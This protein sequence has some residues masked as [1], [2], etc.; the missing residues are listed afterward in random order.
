MRVRAVGAARIRHELAACRPDLRLDAEGPGLVL[1]HL[2]EEA[3]PA[4]RRAEIGRTASLRGPGDTLLVVAPPSLPDP[5]PPAGLV[6]TAR[7]DI[8][9]L[10]EVFVLQDGRIG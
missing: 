8:D 6:V 2:D 3:T 1:L 10:G 7:H 9:W 4:Q 5:E